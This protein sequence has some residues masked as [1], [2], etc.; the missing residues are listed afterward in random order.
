MKAIVIVLSAV[1]VSAGVSAADQAPAGANSKLA[2][3]LAAKDA[4]G[5]VQPDKHDPNHGT[6]VINHPLPIEVF[7]DGRAEL[8]CETS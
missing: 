3:M 5:N 6:Y 2:V 8:K 1:L 4:N 7:V